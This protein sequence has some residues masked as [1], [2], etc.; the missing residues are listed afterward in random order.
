MYDLYV[1][2]RRW[3]EYSTLGKLFNW[4][5]LESSARAQK[6]AALGTLWMPRKGF[7]P[8]RFYYNLTSR[9]RY[10]LP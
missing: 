1:G 10:K 9:L 7:Q 6:K 8:L 4:L 5:M 2:A 3:Q